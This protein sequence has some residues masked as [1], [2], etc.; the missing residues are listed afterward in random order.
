[1]Y[2]GPPASRILPSRLGQLRDT[3]QVLEQVGQRDRRG[4]R[5]HP[6]GRHHRRQVIDEVAHHLVGGGACPDDDAGADLGHRDGAGTQLLAGLHARDEVLGVRVGRD[7]PAEV[8]DAPDA[9]AR[10]R[11][12]EVRRRLEVDAAEVLAGGHRVHEVV[13]GVDTGQGGVER[14][15]R[16][17]IGLDDL[18]TLP[19]PRLE[20][21]AAA[22]S[23][24]HAPAARQEFGHE[25]RADVAAGAEDQRQRACRVREVHA[26]RIPSVGV[27]RIARD[28][29]RA[30]AGVGHAPHRRRGARR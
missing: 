29:S 21:A 24:A 11:R 10:R 12:R 18:G 5:L 17:R 15:G 22:R 23:G 6:A 1:M 25:I 16:Q 26:P 28:R 20:H 3:D 2:S 14:V 4:L 7:E 19:V 30:S 9:G 13:G 8:D 27:A